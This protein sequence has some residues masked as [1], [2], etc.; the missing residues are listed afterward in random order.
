MTS[1]PAGWY[2]ITRTRFLVGQADFDFR[3][4]PARGRWT[5]DVGAETT[6]PAYAVLSHELAASD[7]V[8]Q[9]NAAPPAWH[10]EYVRSVS[11]DHRHITCPACSRTSYHPQGR[12]YGW[13]S[14]CSS[15]TQLGDDEVPSIGSLVAARAALHSG[16][17]LSD[18]A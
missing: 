4:G 13:C 12:A 17:K 15:Y 18:A 2:E 10:Y 16:R 9:R 3:D 6:P 1:A 11:L 5:L 7:L 14:Q 8:Y